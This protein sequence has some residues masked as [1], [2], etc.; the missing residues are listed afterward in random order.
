MNNVN[1]EPGV[2]FGAGKASM[3]FDVIR[4]ITTPLTI[5]QFLSLLFN[6]VVYFC[7]NSR[8][9][10][11]NNVCLYNNNANACKMGTLVSGLAIAGSCAML[12]AE[13]IFQTTSSIKM[14]RYSIRGSLGIAGTFAVLYFF[15]FAYLS[16][17]WFKA[18]YPAFG[19][20][21][22]SCRTAIAFSFF[23]IFTFAGSAWLAY[24]RFMAG[25][26]MTTF[27]SG[28]D[29]SQLGVD[30]GLRTG[31]DGTE[32]TAYAA[33]NVTDPQYVD[34]GY[35]QNLQDVNFQSGQANY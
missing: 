1:L 18:S 9:Y 10:G 33:G 23:A 17:S 14:R 5:L 32:F 16:S 12:G 29:A 35:N 28:Y 21:L 24:K 26:D 31:A 7:I 19:T 13:Y 27:T 8:G 6:L 30:G 34:Q 11:M 4:Y 22:N 3:G 20:G 25:V 2:A 15:N